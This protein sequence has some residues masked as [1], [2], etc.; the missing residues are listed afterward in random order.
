MNQTPSAGIEPTFQE[1]ESCVLSITPRGHIIK[2]TCTI[3]YTDESFFL[4]QCFCFNK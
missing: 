1:P 3:Y 4:Q 2:L